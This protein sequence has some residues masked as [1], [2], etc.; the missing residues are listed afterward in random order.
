MKI[1]PSMIIDI[2]DIK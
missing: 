1:I 2:L